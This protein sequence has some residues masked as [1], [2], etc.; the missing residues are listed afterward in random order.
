M[1]M[2]R[3][4]SIKAHTNRVIANSL[5]ATDQEHGTSS[6]PLLMHTLHLR[7]PLRARHV[8]WQGLVPSL[9]RHSTV[10]PSPHGRQTCG[11]TIT[12]ASQTRSMYGRKKDHANK[13]HSMWVVQPPSPANSSPP[14]PL[15]TPT[16]TSTPPNI[17][18]SSPSSSIISPPQSS[19]TPNT[20]PPYTTHPS[21]AQTS[22]T[23]T[24]IPGA[25]LSGRLSGVVSL[26]DVLNLIAK[27]SGLNPHDPGEARERRR[28][29]SS[30]S[31]TRRSVDSARSESVGGGS[32]VAGS[33][34]GSVSGNRRPPV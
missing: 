5:T 25:T 2:S 26:T 16:I 9:P 28:R 7:H 34:R 3:C 32:S 31:A 11:Y 33:R 22:V 12:S 19:I 17:L 13:E 20:G 27:V 30:A 18:S 21:T 24:A 29:S 15:M 14:T 1:S 23:A 4:V 8:R 10:N 6:P